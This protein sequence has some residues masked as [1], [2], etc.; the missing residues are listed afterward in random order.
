LAYN[1]PH[2]PYTHS[3]LHYHNHYTKHIHTY[4]FSHFLH[5]P[6]GASFWF[7]FLPHKVHSTP[8]NTILYHLLNFGFFNYVV[9]VYEN[10]LPLIQNLN[11]NHLPFLQ[12]KSIY[13]TVISLCPPIYTA[14]N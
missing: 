10:N 12:C 6:Q 7:S 1:K 11:P 3:W 9:F 5:I 4:P 2:K 13:H 8:N 14:S